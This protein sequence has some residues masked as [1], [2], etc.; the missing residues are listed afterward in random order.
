MKF[1]RLIPILIFSLCCM[2]LHSQNNTEGCIVKIDSLYLPKCSIKDRSLELMLDST[3]SMFRN[4]QIG[5]FDNKPYEYFIT[6]SKHKQN[7]SVGTVSIMSGS[8]FVMVD[9]DRD[10]QH[11]YS[12]LMLHYKG[13]QIFV[14][15]GDDIVF[16]FVTKEVDVGTYYRYELYDP[17]SGYDCWEDRFVIEEVG[18][19][20][21]FSNKRFRLSFYKYVNSEF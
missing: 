15:T 12:G 14:D 16:D 20:M 13:Y 6:I 5:Q 10:R 9:N 3:L 19:F 2:K 4:D 17:V 7:S 21:Y 11:Y 1:R 18:F 8:N